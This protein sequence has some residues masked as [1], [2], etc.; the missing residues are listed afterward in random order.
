MN[1]A[2]RHYTEVCGRFHAEVALPPRKRPSYR[3]E[4]I[5]SGAQGRRGW[6]WT[7]TRLILQDISILWAG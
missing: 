7:Q 2:A 1:S 3:S 5:L 4:T 6:R